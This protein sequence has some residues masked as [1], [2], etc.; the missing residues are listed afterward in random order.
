MFAYQV[1]YE[2]PEDDFEERCYDALKVSMQHP[3]TSLV[4]DIPFDL[5]SYFLYVVDKLSERDGSSKLMLSC[6]KGFV[7]IIETIETWQAAAAK[8]GE[9]ARDVDSNNNEEEDND[10]TRSDDPWDRIPFDPLVLGYLGKCTDKIT[11]C[12]DVPPLLRRCHMFCSECL[13][14]RPCSLGVDR[15][16][17]KGEV[18]TLH[19]GSRDHLLGT[20]RT[21]VNAQIN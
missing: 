3:D 20:S 17:P 9:G 18:L 14:G 19:A 4:L 8:T 21:L 2:I 13:M 6:P 15:S 11:I 7:R 12:N 1:C 10:A 16:W 5:G